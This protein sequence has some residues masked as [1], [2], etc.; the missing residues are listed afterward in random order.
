MF[1]L[2]KRPF[3]TTSRL[4]D[5]GEE[6]LRCPSPLSMIQV[7]R[8]S[9]PLVTPLL[10]HSRHR[11]FPQRKVTKPDE[12]EMPLLTGYVQ[13]LHKSLGYVSSHKHSKGRY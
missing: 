8:C 13:I 3:L 11:V 1:L 12:E 4:I 2:R 7:G 9:V 5:R 6:I 10:N